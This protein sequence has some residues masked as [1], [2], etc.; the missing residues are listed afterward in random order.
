MIR[1]FWTILLPMSLTGACAAVLLWATRPL[2]YRMARTQWPVGAMG[3]ALCLFAV[4]VFRMLPKNAPTFLWVRSA[5]DMLAEQIPVPTV[6]HTAIA[7]TGTGAAAA[8]VAQGME[9]AA[10]TPWLWYLVPVLW[11]AGTACALVFE[12]ASYLR[13]N[14]RLRRSSR[15]VTDA[16]LL[17]S[18]RAAQQK[19]DLSRAPQLRCTAALASPLAVG[20]LHPCIYLPSR[21]LTPE[22]MAHALHHECMH[23]RRGHLAWKWLAQLVCAA[24][25][26]NPAAWLL[27][28][29]LNEA[30]EFDCD[31]A[32]AV[33]LDGRQRKQYC[34]ALLDAADRGRLPLCIS[35]F[36]RPASILRRRMEAVLA[37]GTGKLRRM[38]A[39]VLCGA[40]VLGVSGLTA[41]AAGQAAESAA[42]QLAPSAAQSA[43]QGTLPEDG[44]SQPGEDIPQSDATQPSE[45][46]PASGTTQTDASASQDGAAQPQ[47]L[48]PEDRAPQPGSDVPASGANDAEAPT[49]AAEERAD[50]W[51]WPVPNMECI[52]TGFGNGGHRGVDIIASKDEAILA[53]RGGTVVTASPGRGEDEH[54][55]YG[56]YI[57]I[58]H[59][60]GLHSLYAHCAELLVSVGDE[61]TAGQQIARV[62]S[63]GASTGYHCHVE[64]MQDGVLFDPLSALSEP[65]NGATPDAN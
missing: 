42:N 20:V 39:A 25:W 60:N 8:P 4:P 34:A 57:E 46:L 35:A 22:A 56:K 40:L 32:V 44:T 11:A 53:V 15:P 31:R 1:F 28:R 29:L 43:P 47:E 3:A 12:A 49:A 62:G 2:L 55:S 5:S 52:A 64:M 36:A 30:C 9:A 17:A 21:A 51:V 61:V 48:P 14:V 65:E 38:A 23:L 41:C 16:A 18:L 33:A 59:G 24:H 26:F 19:S 63:T 6:A 58:D 7:G 54:W 45:A 37:P 50:E 10:R 13:F 27:L